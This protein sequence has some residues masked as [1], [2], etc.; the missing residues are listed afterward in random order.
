MVVPLGREYTFSLMTYRRFP[1]NRRKCL[2]TDRSKLH[3]LG[4]SEKVK[5][6]PIATLLVVLEVG[7]V[8][9][10]KLLD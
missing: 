3:K 2:Y 6:H 1:R 7:R 8:L 9:R 5:G 4:V 10:F